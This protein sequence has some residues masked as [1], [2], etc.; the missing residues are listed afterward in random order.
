MAIAYKV[1]G[2]LAATD[3]AIPTA[4]IGP[5]SIFLLMGA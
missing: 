1:L 3:S 2:Q 5:D 4:P